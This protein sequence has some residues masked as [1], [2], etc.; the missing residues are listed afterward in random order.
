M[1][2]RKAVKLGKAKDHY[3]LGRLHAGGY[4]LPVNL[5]EV[6]AWITLA[7]KGEDKEHVQKAQ[8]SLSVLLKKMTP[9]Q[10]KKGRARFRELME[11][12]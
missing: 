11:G 4:G 9:E 5:V 8:K 6:F 3:S 2:Y 12:T 7:S 1:W 10:I